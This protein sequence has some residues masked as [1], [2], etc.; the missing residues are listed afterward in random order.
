M[1]WGS[2]RSIFQAQIKRR[3]GVTRHNTTRCGAS[4]NGIKPSETKKETEKD[5]QRTEKDKKR[6]D[7]L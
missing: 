6:V 1:H 7:S 3:A 2:L 4:K 5:I